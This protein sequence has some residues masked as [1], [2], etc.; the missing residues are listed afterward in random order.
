MVF[1]ELTVG[2]MLER[3]LGC[4][5]SEE[6][7]VKTVPE[8]LHFHLSSFLGLLPARPPRA[9]FTWDDRRMVEIA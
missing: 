7:E 4:G 9:R 2:V 5:G 6:G 1:K 8:N 3:M